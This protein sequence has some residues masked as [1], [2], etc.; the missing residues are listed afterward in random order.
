M[1]W[2]TVAREWEAFGGG[3]RARWGE[4]TDDDLRD[5][6]GSRRALAAKLRERYQLDD[7]V[8]EAEIDGWLAGFSEPLQRRQGALDQEAAE[9]EGMGQARYAP[10]DTLLPTR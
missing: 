3:I 1:D 8:A 9:N 2:T 10:R 5:V 4:V 6:G 7:D